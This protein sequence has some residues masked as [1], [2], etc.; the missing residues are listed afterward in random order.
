MRKNCAKCGRRLT[1]LCIACKTENPPVFQLCINCNQDYRL[2]A[3]EHYS[4]Q[5]AKLELKIAH[6]DTTVIA[7]EQADLYTQISQIAIMVFA[8]IVGGF[9][10]FYFR[11]NIY[12]FFA[13]LLPLTA[14]LVNRYL[15]E[16]IALLA[17]GL[18][19]TFAKEWPY[20]LKEIDRQTKEHIDARKEL[21]Y[22]S[23][24]LNK[25]RKKAERS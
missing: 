12:S 4:K 6:Q 19:R 3:V 21:E 1:I 20:I 15:V 7:K 13:V 25:F 9:C 5:I 17:V 8:L 16:K 24:E 14:F 10:L 11:A 2:Y 23:N 18:P 22:Y